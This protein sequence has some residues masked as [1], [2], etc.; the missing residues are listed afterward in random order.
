MTVPM[1]MRAASPF[2]AVQSPAVPS[3]APRP[4]LTLVGVTSACPSGLM[5]VLDAVLVTGGVPTEISV[6]RA[7]ASFRFSVVVADS[8]TSPQ[9]LRDRVA[10]I[11][12]VRTVAAVPV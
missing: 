6:R 4:R 8:D 2:V 1:P 5:R 12:G 11:V 9:R 7:S 10:Q 3:P